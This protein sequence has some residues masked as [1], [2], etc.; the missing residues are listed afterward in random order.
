M[1]IFNIYYLGIFQSTLPRL[2]IGGL[3]IAGRTFFAYY[4]RIMKSK[5]KLHIL[6]EYITWIV[7]FDVV[8]LDGIFRFIFE[9]SMH[10][11]SC[12]IHIKYL[13]PRKSFWM[14]PVHGMES[15]CVY[16]YVCARMRACEHVVCVC[17]CVCV[18]KAY[19]TSLKLLTLFADK[20]FFIYFL[21]NF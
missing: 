17:A 13:Q 15:V 5:L 8:I 7:I 4:W 3:Q 21:N 19:I 2:F 1:A 12:I 11:I 6:F 16:V 20:Y 10:Q 9:I 14:F 18:L